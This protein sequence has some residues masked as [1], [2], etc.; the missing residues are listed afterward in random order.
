MRLA[1]RLEAVDVPWPPGRGSAGPGPE[2]ANEP[3]PI[4]SLQL[5]DGTACV[6]W[7]QVEPRPMGPWPTGGTVLFLWPHLRG[8]L[9]RPGWARRDDDPED[10]YDPWWNR[11]DSKVSAALL[12]PLCADL[13]GFLAERAGPARFEFVDRA[14]PGPWSLRR[15][16]PGGRLRELATAFLT[17][18]SPLDRLVALVE[19]A[20]PDDRDACTMSFGARRGAMLYARRN[21]R[22]LWLWLAPDLRRDFDRFL[23]QAGGGTRYLRCIMDWSMSGQGLPAPRPP[24]Y[25]ATG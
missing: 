13:V 10:E 9:R 6:L 1:K 20:A 16:A 22:C 4:R 19:G 5:R 23:D 2:A 25:P 8:D 7:D 21:E 12:R 24:S 15:L 3:T 11:E 14:E 18:T 17:R